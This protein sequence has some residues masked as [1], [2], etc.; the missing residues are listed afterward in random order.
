M[1]NNDKNQFFYAWS[2]KLNSKVTKL[3]YTKLFSGVIQHKDG[4]FGHYI[5][6]NYTN[7]NGSKNPE[8]KKYK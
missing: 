3:T 8:H 4:S 7:K 2:I 1:K 5:L 6:G